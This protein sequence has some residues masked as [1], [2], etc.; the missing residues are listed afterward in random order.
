MAEFF[1]MPAISPTMEVGTVVAW[2]VAEGES[3]K[4]PSVVAE[5]GTDKA[6]MDAELFDPGVMLKHL[7]PEGEDAV[8]GFPIAIIGQAADENIDELLIAFE[9][10]KAEKAEPA[11]SEAAPSPAPKTPPKAVKTQAAPV[12][13]TPTA[14]LTRDWMGTPTAHLFSDPPGDLG[15]GAAA[16]RIPASPLAKKVAQTLGLPLETVTGTGPNGRITKSDVLA[17]AT[18][19]K[20]HA[21]PRPDQAI[22]NSR[23]RN[24]IAK[25]LLASHQD[26]PTFFLTVTFDM[27]AA[28]ALRTQLKS[29]GVKI[30]YNDLVISAVA[31]ALR[32]SPAVNASWGADA[33]TR[34][35]RVDIG[36]A[37]AIEDGL[38][39]PVVRG[40]D[41]LS[42]ADISKEVRALAGRAKEGKLTPDEFT[43]STFTIS[44]LGM[45]GIEQFTAIINPPEAAILAVGGIAQVPVAKDGVLALAWQMKVTLTCDH[46]AIDGAT[47]AAFLQKV[48]DYIEAP[49]L[50][51]L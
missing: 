50:L 17:A 4:A 28:V 2:K 34:Y 23:M 44:N 38:I 43:N 14:D 45:F 32:D 29:G 47:G 41:N 31:K 5:I 11:A 8:P 10:E 30:S 16:E 27:D 7:V 6:N 15:I 21:P 46:R 24:T 51:L 12:T 26:V 48:R 13:A 19:G 42:P 20:R 3:F 33:I 40:A 36:V 9:K 37:V 25:R 22:K 18:G 49:A 1:R 39:T 35:G